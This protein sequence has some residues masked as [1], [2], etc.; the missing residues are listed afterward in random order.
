MFERYNLVH[1]ELTDSFSK[2]I[3]NSHSDDEAVRKQYQPMLQANFRLNGYVDV[4]PFFPQVEDRWYSWMRLQSFS[5][6]YS[7]ADYF[8]A[9]KDV[10]S[11]LMICT[12]SGKGKMSYEEK[13]FL[14]KRGDVLWIDCH[15]KHEYRT[16]ADYWE[17]L[18]LHVVG[19]GIT[20][21]YDAYR[22]NKEMLIHYD[23]PDVLI[24]KIELL[25][26]AY[27]H[28]SPTKGI[29]CA[30]AVTAILTDL[31]DH[32]Y[33]T[34]IE[35]DEHSSTKLIRD[36]ISYIHDHF[37]ETISLDDLSKQVSLS[38]YHLSR[39]FKKQTGF[40]PNDYLI[41]LR[42]EHARNLLVNSS[43]PIGQIGQ[44]SGF[45]NEAYFSRLFKQKTGNSPSVYRER[46][47]TDRQ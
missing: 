8:T 38:K 43:L 45:E 39:E 10:D 4:L 7:Q 25:L 33:G 20:M 41:Q 28:P 26:D 18:D 42:M 21:Y 17:H 13:D 34:A 44:L 6:M 12:I 36:L 47:F 24:H 32:Q 9:R 30:Y 3:K 31:I 37:K 15:K 11:Y 35:H 27:T 19:E 2:I 40:P 23:D 1:Y 16:E 46:F 22:Q 29:D 5:H 14:L